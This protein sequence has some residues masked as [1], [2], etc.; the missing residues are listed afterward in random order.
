MIFEY[1]MEAKKQL[2][3]IVDIVMGSIS[4]LKIKK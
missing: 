3:V 4:E 1:S 2:K